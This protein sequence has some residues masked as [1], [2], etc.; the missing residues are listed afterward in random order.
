MVLNEDK[1]HFVVAGYRHE[2]H[3]LLF[4]TVGDAKIWESNS[5]LLLGVTIDKEMKFKEHLTNLC[6]KVSRNISALARVSLC[7]T[8]RS[9]GFYSNHLLSLNLVTIH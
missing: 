8:L 7:M 4:A 3:E 1:C 5:E 6:K 9:E 2:P